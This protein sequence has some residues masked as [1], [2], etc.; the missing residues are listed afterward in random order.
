MTYQKW[1]VAF[2]IIGSLASGIGGCRRD[3]PDRPAGQATGPALQQGTTAGQPMTNSAVKEESVQMNN[4][5]QEGP[6]Q[7]Q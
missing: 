1:I 6:S 2:M 4:R 3:K 5:G 7:S